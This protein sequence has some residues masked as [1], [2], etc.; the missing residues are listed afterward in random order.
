MAKIN[1]RPTWVTKLLRVAV[2]LNF[3]T[4]YIKEAIGGQSQSR[5]ILINKIA[6]SVL[7]FF[8]SD[9]LHGSVLAL[10]YS[11]ANVRHQ[12]TLH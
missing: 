10:I 9:Q 6:F 7:T 1:F 5:S 3:P 2:S 8:Y 11:L 4:I 12:K